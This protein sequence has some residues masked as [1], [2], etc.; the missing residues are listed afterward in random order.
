[1][2][3]MNG[4]EL[5]RALRR[6]DVGG[7]V[8]IVLLTCRDGT[9]DSI[10][11]RG[12]GVDDF[13]TKPFNKQELIA[14]VQTGER[15]LALESRDVV[16]FSM[17]RLAESR[18]PETGHHLERVQAYCGVLARELGQLER[19]GYETDASYVRLI[20]LTAPLHDIGKIG[21]P[22]SV[23]LKPGRLNDREFEM[24]KA[25]TTLGAE[26]LDA[27]IE[28]YPEAKFLRMARDIALTHHERFDG[29]GYPRGLAGEGIPLCGRIAALADVYDALTSARIYKSALRHDVA[30]CIISEESPGHFDPV[31]LECFQQAQPRFIEIHERYA[32]AHRK[33]PASRNLAGAPA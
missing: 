30:R 1:M 16:L 12:A 21:I 20:C 4:L 6:E 3:G 11:A 27:A 23:L 10:A 15:I 14:R 2:P 13:V 8:Y 32:Q 17:A 22:D 9:F 31:I 26:T 28:R 24:M 33:S 18:D 5:C 19:P 25:H 7:Y 29:S